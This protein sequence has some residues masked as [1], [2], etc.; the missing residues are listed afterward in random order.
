[1]CVFI[2]HTEKSAKS[3]GQEAVGRLTDLGA[4]GGG[5]SS[6]SGVFVSSGEMLC[7]CADFPVPGPSPP[8]LAAFPA[9]APG[10]PLGL[11]CCPAWEAWLQ[12]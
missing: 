11:C 5:G 2:K 6:W 4:W 3:Q 12:G 8:G 1:M 10:L 9:M 7:T